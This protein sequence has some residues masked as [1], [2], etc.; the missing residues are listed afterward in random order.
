[1]LTF[2]KKM[3]KFRVGQK[4][5][6]GAAKKLGFKPIAGLVGLVGGYRAMRRHH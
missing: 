6:R 4:V 2:L 5:A 1:M 3:I